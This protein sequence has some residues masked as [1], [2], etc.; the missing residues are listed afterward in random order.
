MAKLQL[1]VND[2]GTVRPD[3]A[4]QLVDPSLATTVTAGSRKKLLWFCETDHP[5]YEWETEVS[6]R[7]RGAGCW[8]CAGKVVLPGWNDL[9]TLR[10]DL[11]KQLVNPSEA[12]T[13]T[14]SSGKQL[15]WFCETGH[16]RY[17]WEARVNTRSNGSDCGVCAGKAVLPGWN[18]LATVRPDLAEQLADPSLATTVTK[19]S[20]KR[21]LWFCETGH[22]RHEWEATV[23]DRSQGTGC[24]AC[25]GKVVLPGWNDLGTV[26]PDLAEQL[27][28][29][30]LGT[31]VTKGSDKK[32][33]WFCETG[34]PRHE[35][36][37]TVNTRS[38]G[39]GCGVCAESGYDSSKPG[40]FYRFEFVDEGVTFLCYG[41]SNVIDT[42][43]KHYEGKLDLRNFQ[44]L[45]FKDGAIPQEIEKRF[46]KV[47]KESSAPA[48]TCGVAGTIT[49]S[50]SLSP[51]N[52]EL[53]TSFEAVW[54]DAVAQ[55]A[56]LE[57]TTA[58]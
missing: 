45:H 57:A 24:G 26:R 33:L 22:P 18:D 51:E 58:A 50:F 46:H 25:D 21:L 13:V 28:D 41:I 12:K 44:S 48:S 19:F 23:N 7:S 35:W 8:V 6:K 1:G 47:R 43:R 20:N 5:R 27:V 37:A 54:A 49:E 9:G 56:S 16:P 14:K 38:R 4:E 10:P 32:F 36:E 53:L 39:K 15:S 40:W 30:S 11:A 17:E 31:T 52:W 42:R 29:P 2:L 55:Q 3:L 34:H